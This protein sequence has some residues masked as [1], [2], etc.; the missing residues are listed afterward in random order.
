[1]VVLQTLI[2]NKVQRSP[3]VTHVISES[4]D[5]SACSDDPN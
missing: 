2:I 4:A 1:M 5:I 3:Y